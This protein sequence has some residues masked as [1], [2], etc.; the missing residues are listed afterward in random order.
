[1]EEGSETTFKT[2]FSPSPLSSMGSE[3][4][5]E[6]VDPLRQSQWPSLLFNVFV[7]AQHAQGVGCL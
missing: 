5:S 1:M 6:G 4:C 7:D 2:Q 3:V